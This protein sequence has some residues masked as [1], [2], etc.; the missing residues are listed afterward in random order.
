[1][2]SSQ[3]TRV[4]CQRRDNAVPDMSRRAPL[5]ALGIGAVGTIASWPRLTA[6]EIPGRG[7]DV[8]TIALIFGQRSPS[9]G[10]TAG[11]HR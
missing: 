4:S 10:L 3:L 5:A 1:M 11:S 2:L 6:S 8:L 9:E 7:S